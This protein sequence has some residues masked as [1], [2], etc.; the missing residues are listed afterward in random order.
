MAVAE[1][2]RVHLVLPEEIVAQVDGLVGPRKRSQFIADA[3]A[4]QINK[5]REPDFL[6]YLRKSPVDDPELAR[7]TTHVVLPSDLLDEVDKE[8]GDGSRSL[9][10]AEAVERDLYRR[11][12]V[13]LFRELT[14]DPT[15]RPS[16]P[17][18]AT[19]ESTSQWVR[20]LREEAD[21]R[22]EEKWR[23]AGFPLS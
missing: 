19:E 13:R 7:I 21:R 20:D 18:W 8:V 23:D 17:A 5:R 4:F 15:A 10:I 11:E 1:K 3:V 2:V 16:N 9:F 14:S 12:T 6:P 22:L